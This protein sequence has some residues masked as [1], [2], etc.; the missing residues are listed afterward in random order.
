MGEQVNGL[1]HIV[2]PEFVFGEEARHLVPAFVRNFGAQ[3]VLV[4]TDDG[5]TAAGWA[6][7]VVDD[8]GAAGIPSTIFSAVVTN[9]RADQ[10]AEGADV[11]RRDRCDTIVAVG[12]GSVID[13]AKG[14]GIV[15]SHG[16]DIREFCGVD[17]VEQAP[18]PLVC[19]STTTTSAD[20]SQFAIVSDVERR[21]K[22]AIIS[23][24]IV[25]DVSLLDPIVY[26]TLPAD[27][28]AMC[29][30]DSLSQAIEAYVSNAH[31]RFTD[32]LALDAARLVWSALPLVNAEPTNV[33]YRSDLMFGNLEG[34]MA[35][36]NAS[37]GL[38]HAAAHVVGGL[39]DAHHGACIAAVL[40]SVIEFN[41][42][43][44]PE[45]FAA[46]GE[47]MGVSLGS[48]GAANKAAAF[49]GAVTSMQ[50]RIG[51]RVT[52]TDLGVGSRDID[53]LV[54]KALADPTLLTNPRPAT[55]ADIRAVYERSL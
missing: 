1:H 39:T 37:L 30:M 23:K 15:F 41:Y 4:V 48:G 43:A 33:S 53:F 22:W 47:A 51:A 25:P 14:I 16:R 10:M 46:L 8:L 5:V 17:T 52:L 40:P 36:S 54:E 44:V 38:A 18:P 11:C 45:R 9:P 20:V 21:E 28:T 50:E 27:L 55:A 7:E 34:G 31:S 24:M 13:C 29:G 49:A 6:G 12:G 19:V 32:L 35:F 42:Q 3:H 2:V 26:T